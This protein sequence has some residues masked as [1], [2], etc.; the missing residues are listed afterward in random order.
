VIDRARVRITALLVV[1]TVLFGGIAIRLVDLQVISRDDLAEEALDQRLVSYNIPATRGTIFDRNGRDLALDVPR[2]FAFVDPSVVLHDYRDDYTRS[3]ASVL[4][5]DEADIETLLRP[6]TTS[7]GKPIRYRSLGKKPLTIEQ[8]DAIETLQLPGVGLETRTVRIYPNGALAAPL[9]G[10][11]HYENESLRGDLGLEAVYDDDLTGS[12][13]RA[14]YER[15]REGREIPHSRREQV[16]AERGADLVLTIDAALQAQ[17]ERTLIDQVT[18]QNAKQGV[19]IV[20]DVHTG[21]ILAMATVVGPDESGR[22][23]LAS[24]HDGNFA[25][26]SVFEPG[27]TNKVITIASALEPGGCDLTPDTGFDVPWRVTNGDG[28]IT[29]N[30]QHANKWWTTREILA[31]SSNVGTT[32]IA[33]RC[34]TPETMDA[35]LRSF[36]YGTRTTLGLPGEARGIL[37][38]PDEYYTTGLKTAAIGYGVATTP[39]QVL[40]VFV[41]IANGGRA[42]QPRLVSATIAPDGERHELEVAPG[43]RVVSEATTATMADML[44]GVVAAGTAPCAAVAGYEVAG[45]TGTT[46]KIGTNGQYLP[47]Q[48]MATF[49]GFAPASAPRL[50]AIVVL[51]EPADNSG[52]AASAPVFS[53]IM[54]FALRHVAAAPTAPSTQVL[55]WDA[56]A[57]V[58]AERE[59]DCHIPHGA[60]VDAIA[61]ARAETPGPSGASKPN[62]IEVMRDAARALRDRAGTV[63]EVPDPEHGTG[64]EEK[65]Q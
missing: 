27:S 33:D 50:A 63:D 4:H 57:A 17:V 20:A 30:S 3:L 48:N 34:F 40:N 15:D 39:L 1:T 36:G 24:A 56:A 31:Q 7:E 45:K 52:G 8:R 38:P 47:G 44:L 59:I 55:Q 14:E 6:G 65:G 10:T 64:P 11:A 9:L 49:V 16:R 53:E 18:A 28:F 5:I 12:S 41:T 35:A 21:D 37:T 26:S 22:A 61:A 46:R 25:V 23:Q 29:D 60:E 62:L 32:L 42:V 58:V 13:G 54:R 19:A 43:R 51:D 2:D